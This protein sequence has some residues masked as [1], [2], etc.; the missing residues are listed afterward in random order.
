MTWI[1][2]R[3]EILSVFLGFKADLNADTF[4]VLFS[5][6][7]KSIEFSTNVYGQSLFGLVGV[8]LTDHTIEIE[9]Q[10]TISSISYLC[11]YI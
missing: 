10:I 1:P 7:R 5:F 11:F 2:A 4:K 9:V 8:I 3:S 6:W